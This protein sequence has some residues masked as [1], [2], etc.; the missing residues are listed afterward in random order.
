LL[1]GHSIRLLQPGDMYIRNER[2]LTVE[3]VKRKRGGGREV[4][5]SNSYV[6][7]SDLPMYDD[8][9]IDI[10]RPRRGF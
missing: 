1:K 9:D 10:Y 4:R 7:D 3:D 2:L 5:L 6:F 8:V